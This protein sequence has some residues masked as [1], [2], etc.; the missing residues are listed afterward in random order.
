MMGGF[1]ILVGVLLFGLCALVLFG[2]LDPG[3]LLEKKHYLFFAG[4]LVIIGIFDFIIG[5][6]LAR[7]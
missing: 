2:Y 5:I 1:I 3:L 6:K 4:V 7:W